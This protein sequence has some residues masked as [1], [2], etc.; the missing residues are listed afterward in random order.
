MIMI[1]I[2]LYHAFLIMSLLCHLLVYVTLIYCA[3]V[4]SV[5]PHVLLCEILCGQ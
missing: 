5:V 4:V 2:V 3:C 1:M